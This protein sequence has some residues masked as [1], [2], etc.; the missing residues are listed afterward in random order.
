MKT[1]GDINGDGLTDLIA[2]GNSSGGLVWYQ[3]PSWTKHTID[4]GDGF[5]T[6]GEVADVD[7]D[8]DQDVVVLT[9]G[10]IR[11]YENP[12]WSVHVIDTRTFHDVEVSDLDGDGDVDLV[13]R[14][15]GEF[16]HAGNELHFYQQN[17]PTTWTHRAVNCSN[18]EG[19]KVVDMDKDNDQDAVIGGAWFE[20]TKDIIGGTWTSYSYTTSWTHPNAF[21][22][23][24]DINNDAR[25]DIVLAPAE[26]T[27][28]TY[29]ISWFQAPEN[30]KSSNWTEH[31]V[32]NNVETVQ[33]FVGVADMN[34][35]GSLDI[36]AAGMQQGNDPD[37]VK[38]Y[39]NGDVVGGSWTKQV[40]ATTGSHSMRIGDFNNDGLLDL[41]GANWQSP[42]VEI[43]YNDSS[44]PTPS[45]SI[46]I[47]NA[48]SNFE[49]G[50]LAKISH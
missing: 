31:I 40:I 10:D 46:S 7:K 13:A 2:G 11:W 17:T 28:G 39:L 15:Q 1:V 48:F 44:I 23:T 21:V 43:W 22:S 32:E 36:V 35:D 41:Y 14:D 27:G 47:F 26:L 18:G 8:G 19:L 34:N 33:H 3:S 5:S 25:I 16:G 37:E 42:V 6:D 49:P 12:S 4:T 45:I 30:P 20:N 24:G 50:Q 29:R 9:N 38:V